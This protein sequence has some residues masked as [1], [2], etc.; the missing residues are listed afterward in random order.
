MNRIAFSAVSVVSLASLAG[1]TMAAAPARAG[2]VVIGF[3]AGDGHG[4]VGGGAR[5]PERRFRPP[6]IHWPRVRLD[7]VAFE[8]TTFESPP[9]EPTAYP[10]EYPMGG[11][12]RGD[13][14]REVH[15]RFDG[16]G[17][18]S[19][20]N[21]VF[22]PEHDVVTETTV[23][24]PAVC[25][26]RV[27]P[28]FATVRGPVYENVTVP[29]YETRRLPMDRRERFYGPPAER[30]VR[31]KVGERF[32]RVQVGERTERVPVGQRVEHVLVRPESTRV[33]PRVE[34]VAGRFV[35]VID[36]RADHGDRGDG[37][38]FDREARLRGEVLTREE[39]QRE[40][41]LV[42]GTHRF[43]PSGR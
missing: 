39:F 29:I 34:H 2:D 15:G 12:A 32:E 25:E 4:Y 23:V 31:V 5:I 24:D 37:R 30:F 14:D 3:G 11:F 7:A 9:I 22:I 18:G 41:A 6:T 16:D 38:G 17:R 28:V 35:I 27:V 36:E 19:S 13:G 20:D 26:D 40:M 10:T 21:R 43:G 8:S 33:V 1:L 42:A